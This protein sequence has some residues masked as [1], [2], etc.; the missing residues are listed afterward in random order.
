MANE[1]LQAKIEE[2]ELELK[3]T[4][5]NKRT[6]AAVGQL[7]GKI[8]KL[9]EEL[10]AKS[11]GGSRGE[12]FAVKKEGD[13]TVGLLGKPSVG[14]STL[15]GKVTNKES[16]I[17]AYEFTTLDC[18]PGLLHFKHTNLQILDLP[19]IIDKAADNRGFGKKVLSVVRACDLVVL[20]IDARRPI[21]DIEMLLRETENSQIKFN[22]DP[23]NIQ[24]RR[25]SH[26]AVNIPL[27]NSS[28][29]LP[30][31][32]VA[33]VLKGMGYVNAEVIIHEKDA[34]VDDVIEA[35]YSNIVYK[36][37]VLCINKIDLFSV[38]ELKKIRDEI[39]EK[40]PQFELFGI[41][42]EAEVNIEKFKDFI[43]DQ[44][45]FMWVYLKEQR[46]DPDLEK[47]LVVHQ[48]DT[49][50]DVCEKIHKDLL[51][52]FRYAKIKGRSAKFDWQ[53]VGLE[54]KVEDRDIV[55]IYAR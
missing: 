19:G 41:S 24:V 35:C 12:G 33:E 4:K 27:N 16:K 8:A 5:V 6:E 11:G 42:A 30:N 9:K 34:T 53:R 29:N 40:Y 31:E 43:W 32:M 38:E 25:M 26:G 44:L 13:A 48:G 7:K 2:L 20:V 49:I 21:E 52:K 36:K 54:H 55:E 37:A 15:L 50:K 17:G 46:K 22:Q 28:D 10:E 18:V 1:V 23:P 39:Q 47:P 14:K 51:K 45:G 3:N